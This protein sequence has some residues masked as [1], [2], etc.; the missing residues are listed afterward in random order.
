MLLYYEREMLK[1]WLVMWGQQYTRRRRNSD[2]HRA[3]EHAGRVVQAD[4]A[5]SG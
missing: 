3:T 1:K 5:T 2:V 4:V